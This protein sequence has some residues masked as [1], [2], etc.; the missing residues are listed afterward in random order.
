MRLLNGYWRSEKM[1]YFIDENIIYPLH[2]AMHDGIYFNRK[3]LQFALE[4]CRQEDRMDIFHEKMRPYY[5]KFLMIDSDMSQNVACDDVRYFI[6]NAIPEDE[7]FVEWFTENFHLW[8]VVHAWANH[9]RKS[10]SES[11][12]FMNLLFCLL[13]NGYECD[14]ES[15]VKEL[16]HVL[17]REEIEGDQYSR[18][19]YCMFH[20]FVMIGKAKSTLY[21]KKELYK[22]FVDHWFVLRFLYSAMFRCIIGCGFTNFVQIPNLMKSSVDYHPFL[23]LFYATAMEQKEE[24]CRRGAKRD[25]LETSLKEIR[26]NARKKQSNELNVLCSIL[27]PKVWKD[28]IEKNRLKNYKELEDEVNSLRSNL[29]KNTNEMQSLID[30]QVE[31]LSETS[32]PIDVIYD[33]LK[34]LSERFPGMAYEV[35]EKLNALLIK[36]EAWAR[37]TAH[38]RDMI[39]EK[40]HQPSVQTTNYY[41]AGAHHND[42]QK[43]LHIT[44]DTKQIEKS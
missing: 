25:K 40:M 30:K 8:D 9:F 20:A 37:N 41:A 10:R 5:R 12:D 38:I 3:N 16:R 2:H 43:H 14:W 4:C 29:E 39:W 32:I 18:S 34:N 44:N 1:E 27:F 7:L 15:H 28:Y 17:L 21:E 13:S 19:I 11:R 35:Y 36:N 23:H 42:N 6:L 24:I 22:L 26:E 33:E 31:M